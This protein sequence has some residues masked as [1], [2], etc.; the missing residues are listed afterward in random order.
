M[1][2]AELIEKLL[3]T[4]FSDVRDRI[5]F[6]PPANMGPES[7]DAT[8]V[9]LLVKNL[10]NN[11]LCYTCEESGPVEVSVVRAGDE[12]IIRV[13][14]HGEG[15]SAEQ[16]SNATEPFYRADS[17]RCRGTGG[18]GLG[19][20]LCRRIAEAHGG[21]LQ[22]DSEPGRGT[23]VCVRLPRLDATESSRPDASPETAAV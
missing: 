23:E 21:S 6:A 18:F 20:Y 15:M 1:N 14:D 9:R 22:I 16:A 3:N 11:A 2:L 8:R 13:K 4:D 12:Q 17:S 19:L 10:I 5:S 7:I